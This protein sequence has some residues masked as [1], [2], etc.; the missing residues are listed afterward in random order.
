M[1]YAEIRETTVACDNACRELKKQ[2]DALRNAHKK[3]YAAF[4]SA[5]ME[6]KKQLDALD[7][8]KAEAKT[9]PEEN[10][11]EWGRIIAAYCEALEKAKQATKARDEAAATCDAVYNAY[12]WVEDHVRIHVGHAI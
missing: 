3:A 4:E 10:T 11:K 7:A 8:I 1:T 2:M 9:I 12:T 6:E 5:C